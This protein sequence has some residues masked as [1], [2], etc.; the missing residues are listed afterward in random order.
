V[1]F[2]TCVRPAV[3][4]S[5]VNVPSGNDTGASSAYLPLDSHSAV[6]NRTWRQPA[7]RRGAR[8]NRSR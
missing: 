6:V 1:V 2:T 5:D 7:T 4:D 3:C 8:S